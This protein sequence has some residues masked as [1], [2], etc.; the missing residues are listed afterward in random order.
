MTT[1]MRETAIDEDQ[2]RLR[3]RSSLLE[4]LERNTEHHDEFAGAVKAG[5]AH[6]R[7]T[8][9]RL[10]QLLERRDTALQTHFD[11]LAESGRRGGSLFD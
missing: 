9:V 1:M 3:L 8:M 4:Y 5:T 6:S 11:L 2:A 10:A 7:D